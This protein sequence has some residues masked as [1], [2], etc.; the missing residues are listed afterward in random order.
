MPR[1]RAYVLAFVA[2]NGVYLALGPRAIP[3]RP[4][5]TI[6]GEVSGGSG[7]RQPPEAVA[8]ILVQARIAHVRL[9]SRATRTLAA[10]R[11]QQLPPP[12]LEV[13]AGLGEL[14]PVGRA[15]GC[16]ERR[17]RPVYVFTARK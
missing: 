7:H 3:D 15:I 9:T 10:P 16:L 17:L 4:I 1:I 6:R 12:D 14:E 13:P 11:P 5:R 8:F 2:A